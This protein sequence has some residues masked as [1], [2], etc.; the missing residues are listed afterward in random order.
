MAGPRLIVPTVE[1]AFADAQ[2]AAPHMTYHGGHLLTNVE[3]YTI[4]WG[5]GWQSLG[6]VVQSLNGFFDYIL[7]S[8]LMDLLAEYGEA[9]QQIGHGS[10]IGTATITNTNPGDGTTVSDDQIR[11][12]LQGWINA[13]TITTPTV[14][15]LYFVYLPPGVS[16][17][18]DGDG[19]CT[20]YCGYHNAAGNIY[21][22]VEP[23]LDC[24]GCNF[25]GG[26]V[27]TNLTK[28]SSHELCEAVTDADLTGWYDPDAGNEIGDVCNSQADVH[29]LGG[30]YV[31]SEWSNAQGACAFAPVG[32]F[33]VSGGEAQPGS[34]ISVVARTP[35]HLDLFVTGTDGRVNSTWWDA[36]TSWA[37]WFNVSGGEA[38][39]GSPISV[40]ARTPDHLDLFVTGTDGRVNSTW[41]DA[42]TSWAPWFNVSGGEAQ[43]GSPI[44]VVARTPDHLDLFVTGTD[45]RV[46]STWWDAATSWAPWFNVSGGEAQPGSPISVVA[47]TPDHLD[48]FV[49]GTDGRIYSTWWDAATSWAPWF[50]VSGGEAQPGSPISV[51]ART[52]DHLDLFV[53]GTDGRIYSTWWDAATS[54]APWFNVSGGEAQPGSPI[55]VVARTPDHLDL[56]ATGTDGRIYSTWWDAATSW[57]P[58][59]NVS[60]GEAQPGSPIS[61]VART[62]DHLDLFATGTDGR[63]DSTW[64]DAATG[65]PG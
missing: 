21:Y 29:Q 54:W 63:I 15:T 24:A 12:A 53:T 31:Q 11:T 40:V 3:V 58:W 45:G 18:L 1:R 61:V 47:R 42:A 56:F 46:N 16:S 6:D 52:P 50:N 64:W 28:V 65:W 48:L 36:A 55:S 44:S 41:W 27:V 4:F 17:T 62:P 2:A 35:D 37:P 43:P 26:D 10:R 23:Y 22:A 25:T 51:V 39:P 30:Y 34:P 38:Q 13:Q 57:A 33:N 49:T 32:W 19:S 20:S 9:G 14:N 5:Q 8:S 59:F 60:G 7:T